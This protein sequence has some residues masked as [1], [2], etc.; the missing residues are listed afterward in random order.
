M[1]PDHAALRHGSLQAGHCD[2]RRGGPIDL[3]VSVDQPPDPDGLARARRRAAAAARRG[4]ARR[5]GTPADQPLSGL[6]GG[7]CTTG[8]R[9]PSHGR[10][11]AWAWRR[12]HADGHRRSL[13]RER[14][15]HR[16]HRVLDDRTDRLGPRSTRQ[17]GRRGCGSRNLAQPAP[18]DRT[19][20]TT[21]SPRRASS[22]PRRPTPAWSWPTRVEQ[23]VR[24]PTVSSRREG[25]HRG[26][27]DERRSPRPS[28]GSRQRRAPAR[29]S[30]G[31]TTRSSS[32]WT[33]TTRIV[34]SSPPTAGRS[35]ARH[36]GHR[37]RARETGGQLDAADHPRAP[38]RTGRRSTARSEARR[39]A[40]LE[41]LVRG[42]HAARAAHRADQQRRRPPRADRTGRPVLASRACSRCR[43]RPATPHYVYLGVWPHDEAI[44]LRRQG[45]APGQPGQRHRR[46]APRRHAAR[47]G[48]PPDSITEASPTSHRLS[49]CS[50]R[51]GYRPRRSSSDLG[52]DPEVA[53]LAFECA[54]A[55]EIV[56]LAALVTGWQG[57]A[58]IDL[59][60]GKSIDA[61]KEALAIEEEPVTVT[62]PTRTPRSS[63]LC[64]TP[65][66]RLQF[67]FIEDD[68]E[69]RRA[70]E[71]GD[72]EAWRVFLHPEQRR[73]AERSLERAI[74]ALR[75]RRHRQDRRAA[76][77]RAQPRAQEPRR[78][79]RAH[80]VQHG[81]WRTHSS[82]ISRSST[83]RCRSPRSSV[84]R[85][86]SSPVSTPRPELS[87][88]PRSQTS[89]DAVESVL[90]LQDEP[91]RQ[92]HRPPRVAGRDRLGRVGPSGR[93]SQPDVLPGR[94]RVGR[95]AE[96]RRGRSRSTR[97]F[98]GRDEAWRSTGLAVLPCGR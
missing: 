75:R 1:D 54:D 23:P 52:L 92:G 3:L 60:A 11:T 30:R 67:A 81:P 40:F 7:R 70:I 88:R 10:R 73:Y 82:A 93:A 96:P 39:T 71:D 26:P 65:R 64:S 84:T 80:D 16:G 55:D 66:R 56:E 78:P 45:E 24:R 9:S 32:T 72:F 44:D 47:R 90:G 53:E 14:Q 95:A 35:S 97:R 15:R 89:T 36:R 51:S 19:R 46:T 83:P 37:E 41:K 6:H 62:P 8:R 25:A 87:G 57:V 48:E 34:R 13:R 49:R 94:V 61:V 85:A 50:P 38:A 18:P 76:A 22:R 29:T 59:S 33:S 42:R 68:E 31:P 17:P 21:Y 2:L 20:I 77:P 86:S 5:Q 63:P 4:R 98:V 12:R 27:R 91:H 79:H 58:L 69:L 28:S 74:P 43:A